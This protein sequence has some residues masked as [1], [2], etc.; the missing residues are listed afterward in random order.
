MG[1]AEHLLGGPVTSQIAW[2]FVVCSSQALGWAIFGIQS[3]FFAMEIGVTAFGLGISWALNEA[4]QLVAAPVLGRMSD[5]A[6]RKPILVC[7]F[8]WCATVVGCTAFVTTAWAYIIAR[9]ISGLGQPVQSLLAA[10]L[11]DIIQEKERSSRFGA[12]MAVPFM[13]FVLGSGIGSLLIVIGLEIWQAI[14]VSCVVLF[15]S[16]FISAFKMPETLP[17]SKRKPFCGVGASEE[18]EYSSRGEQERFHS[19]LN[20]GLLLVWFS[21]MTSSLAIV[22]W[23]LTY[24]YLIKDAF[25]WGP[26]EFGFIMMM[27]FLAVGC[28]QG[29]LFPIMD[30]RLG[31]HITAGLGQITLVPAL[32]LLPVTVEN[33]FDMSTRIILH[34][35]VMLVGALALAVVEVSIPRLVSAYVPEPGLMGLAQGGTGSC[36]SVGFILGALVG[37][38]VYDTFGIYGPYLIGAALAT[39]GTGAV[40]GAYYLGEV[41]ETTP[42]TS[43]SKQTTPLNSSPR[44]NATPP[45]P[46]GN[47]YATASSAQQP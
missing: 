43:N 31:S 18:A 15:I 24:P 8:L 37:G 9:G 36:K 6:G 2:F 45:R 42:E 29:L 12:F 32:C 26:T 17:R 21:R 11:T 14:L 27:F 4:A 28:S 1:I 39:I 16:S 33:E 30:K 40:A 22:G 7:S 25:G 44:G 41:C 5:A 35:A 34:G 20:V 13:T 47:Y 19:L 10:V 23:M 46:R 3:T 38:S